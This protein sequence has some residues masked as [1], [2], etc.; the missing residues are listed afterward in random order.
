MSDDRLPIEAW[1]AESLRL[2]IFPSK[3]GSVEN[4]GWLQNLIGQPPEVEVKHPREG[5]IRTEATFKTGRLI[6]QTTPI[7]ID[8]NLIPSPEQLPTTKGFLT[9][10][11]FT[12]IFES[13]QEVIMKWLNLDSFPQ[14]RRIAFGTVLLASVDSR[15]AGYRQLAVYLPSVNIDPDHST[16]LLYQINRV[17]DST[18]G[19]EN[20][21][22][23]RLSKW[24]VA[25]LSGAGLVI[26]PPQMSL[27]EAPQ[28]YFACRLELDIN[29]DAEQR[30][31]LPRNMIPI[32]ASELISLG[33]EII[34][35]GDIP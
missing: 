4:V 22:I 3:I 20:L 6:M 8:L 19:V 7:R 15:A 24:S 33:K 13:F 23:N 26:E 25:M 28:K 16:D 31:A 34:I 32:I 21:K 9:L 14:I 17:R 18:S 11:S 2:T 29:T 5:G 10:G 12:E 30:I 1:S 35:E 27:V